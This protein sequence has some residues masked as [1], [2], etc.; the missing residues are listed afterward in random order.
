MLVNINI[1]DLK[2]RNYLVIILLLITSTCFADDDFFRNDGN[3]DINR[4][5]QGAGFAKVDSKGNVAT[6]IADSTSG[7][8][9]S[10]IPVSNA[11]G[12]NGAYT[13]ILGYDAF[14]GLSDTIE[15]GSTT[16]VLNLTAHVA[17][18]GDA[19]LYRGASVTANTGVQIP[20]CSVTVNTVT[21]CYPFPATPGLETVAILRPTPI[22]SVR[23]G[24]AGQ[25][26][27][28]V[29]L[30]SQSQQS[31]AAGLLKAEDTAAASGDAG[32]VQF[33]VRNDTAATLTGTDSD[34][35]IPVVNQYGGSVIDLDVRFQGNG[36]AARSPI[37]QEDAVSASQDALMVAGS[38]VRGDVAA[39][40]ADGDY[41]NV[42]VDLDGR[43]Y[44][45]ATGSGVSDYINGC[46]PSAVITNTT[47]T[48]VAADADERFYVTGFECQNT[49]AT[50]TNVIL[51]DGAGTDLARC[52]N[53]ASTAGGNCFVNVGD[54]PIRV[55]NT[56]SLL[57]INVVTTSS[58]TTCCV[59]GYKSPN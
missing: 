50:A 51:E 55:A 35:T 45:N 59:R 5:D 54:V 36:T 40:A 53:P 11:S 7:L 29:S 46:S 48:L 28:L 21:L 52:F 16:T 39:N 3:L 49:S 17:R 31:A 57:Q 37:R 41:A 14:N 13:P 10:V 9:Q 22:S 42:N 30:D 4:N 19:I 56:N 20:V 1:G 15:A 23:A 2:M 58:S 44:V 38:V 34:Y 25:T 6:E 47:Q 8:S 32:V 12:L 18:V 24:S 33:G 43:L 26:S 27:L